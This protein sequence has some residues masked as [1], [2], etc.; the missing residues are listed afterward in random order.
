[1]VVPTIMPAN[2]VSGYE[3]QNSV[4]FNDGDTPKISKTPDAS[5]R[6]TWTIST[7]IKRSTL[8]TN[9]RILGLSIDSNNDFR[10]RFTGNDTIEYLDSAITLELITTNVFRDIAAWY[11]VV[12]V[13]DTTQGT[14]SNRAK[15][16]VNGVLQTSLVKNNG[17]AG[18][19]YPDQNVQTKTGHGARRARTVY[20]RCE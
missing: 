20:C 16:Y 6:R 13:L 12:A 7:W 10:L 5:N 18:A 19:A 11:H 17:D 1:M 15:L 4:R 9:Q 2:S 3:V 8:G 14:A